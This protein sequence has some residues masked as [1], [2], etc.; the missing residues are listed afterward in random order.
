MRAALDAEEAL[1]AEVRQA[2]DDHITNAAAHLV[3]TGLTDVASC[4]HGNP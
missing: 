1:P 3:N 4:R 2:M